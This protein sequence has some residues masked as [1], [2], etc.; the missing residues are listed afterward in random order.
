MATDAFTLTWSDLPQKVYVNPPWN[1]IGIVLSQVYNRSISELI[2]IAPVWKAQAW[3]LLLLQRLIRVPILFPTSSEIIQSVCQNYLLDILPQLTM[4]VISGKD[5]S[6]AIFQEQLQTWSS[7]H[8]GKSSKS[9]D[10]SFCK[11]ASWCNEWDGDPIC[12]HISDVANF[13]AELYGAS[14]Q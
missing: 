11:W 8:G 7:P 3:C 2:L 5:A 10:S 13:L 4:W 14:Y 6:V 1:L 12:G 9:C